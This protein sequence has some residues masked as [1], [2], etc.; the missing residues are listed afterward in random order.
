MFRCVRTQLT[1][2]LGPDPRLASQRA[3]TQ[4]A[5][6]RLNRDYTTKILQAISLS[7]KPNPLILRYIRTARPILSEPS[8][9]DMY[10]VALAD[11]NLLEAWQYQQTFPEGETRMR[12]INKLLRWGFTRKLQS[13]PLLRV[14]D[15]PSQPNQ[16]LKPSNSY[17]GIPSQLTSNPSYILLPFKHPPISHLRPLRPFKTSYACVSF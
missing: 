17:L 1:L 13:F 3:I 7:Q 9:I 5:D 6:A 10:A 11:S 15:I 4:L 2:R 12:L 8:D 16:G 14:F